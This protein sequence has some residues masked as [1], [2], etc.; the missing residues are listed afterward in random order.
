[1]GHDGQTIAGMRAAVQV[2]D[3][4]PEGARKAILSTNI[5]ETSVTIDGVRFVAD[6]GRA[7]EMLH[8][9]S[10]GGGSLQ[11]GWISKAR[12][13]WCRAPAQHYSSR[14]QGCQ[15][16]RATIVSLLTPSKEVYRQSSAEP[17]RKKDAYRPCSP[18]LMTLL[19]R[20]SMRKAA[21]FLGC[22]HLS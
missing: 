10:S 16:R 13:L 1:M 20:L 8:D 2:F 11:E 14:K 12:R 17:L 21:A 22:M 9:A 7:K 4:A 6:S 3:I 15:Q 19:S 5:A 18:E